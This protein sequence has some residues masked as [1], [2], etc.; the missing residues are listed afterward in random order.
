MI[1]YLVGVSNIPSG[2][3]K[4]TG[5]AYQGFSNAHLLRPSDRAGDVGLIPFEMTLSSGAKEVAQKLIHASGGMVRVRL[6]LGEN[7]SMNG[8]MQFRIEGIEAV[9][10]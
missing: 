2:V 3:S 1:R 10:D 4:R 5:K 9:D 8:Q 7:G 6:I